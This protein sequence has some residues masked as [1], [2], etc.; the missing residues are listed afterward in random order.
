M[1]GFQ[2]FIWLRSDIIYIKNDIIKY[3]SVLIGV[4]PWGALAIW[5][6]YISYKES[7]NQRKSRGVYTYGMISLTNWTIQRTWVKIYFRLFYGRRRD[8][9]YF[10]VRSAYCQIFFFL[11][12]IFKITYLMLTIFTVW[13]TQPLIKLNS[14]QSK[15]K[16]QKLSS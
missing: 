5:L 4:I 11:I 8:F 15:I 12:L 7:R 10:L 2:V 16:F 9:Q 3:H 1:N 14:N 13:K 6:A